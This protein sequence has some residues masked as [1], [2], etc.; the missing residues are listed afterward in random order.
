[1]SLSSNVIPHPT[2]PGN[3]IVAYPVRIEEQVIKA[4][5]YNLIQDLHDRKVT[6][7]KFVRSQYGLGLYAAKAVCDT[8]WAHK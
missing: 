8:I 2:S 7:I 1:M 5:E 6:A 4:A 3:V